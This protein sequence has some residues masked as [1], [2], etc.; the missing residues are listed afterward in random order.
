[1]AEAGTGTQEGHGPHAHQAHRAQDPFNRTWSLLPLPPSFWRL[2]GHRMVRKAGKGSSDQPVPKPILENHLGRWAKSLG[3]LSLLHPAGR[4]L[5]LSSSCCPCTLPSRRVSSASCCLGLGAGEPPPPQAC[6]GGH[7]LGVGPGCSTCF[8][9]LLCPFGN[10]LSI[11]DVF[12]GKASSYEKEHTFLKCLMKQ[13]LYPSHWTKMYA[14]L[15]LMICPLLP[16]GRVACPASVSLPLSISFL[17]PLPV[18]PLFFFPF[19]PCPWP[20]LLSV[21]LLTNVQPQRRP[22]KFYFSTTFATLHC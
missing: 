19:P 13:L 14:W 11:W 10:V 8:L 4:L 6:S 22:F 9:P 5:A 1:M 3:S 2:S 20:C 21:S 18:Y 17:S 15:L 16:F 12:Q 7:A